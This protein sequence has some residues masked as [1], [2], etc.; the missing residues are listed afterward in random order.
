MFWIQLPDVALCRPEHQ[1][2]VCCLFKHMFGVICDDWCCPQVQT[3]LQSTERIPAAR[4][5]YR[6]KVSA[7]K[8]YA[9]CACGHSQK[10]VRF[11]SKDLFTSALVE[12]LCPECS[13]CDQ[14]K[15]PED[16]M[17]SFFIQ[18]SFFFSLSVTALTR[19]K[20]QASLLCAS[21]LKRAKQSCCVHARKPKTHR[22]A[23]VHTL[24]SSSTTWRNQ[25]KAFLNHDFKCLR[26]Q[27]P[28][29]DI[30]STYW[31]WHFVP[32]LCV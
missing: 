32:L 7:E 20:L 13:S 1:Q 26:Q 19:A 3:R 16:R 27:S 17:K 28:R 31:I 29:A 9:W 18:L 21:P 22:T 14:L 23:M 10:Q 30:Y 4:L 15:T 11:V 2:Q 5:P 12:V 8:R 6:V 24:M 25:W